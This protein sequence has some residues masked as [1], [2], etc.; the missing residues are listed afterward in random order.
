VTVDVRGLVQVALDTILYPE[1][2]YVYWLRKTETQGQD[3]DE[4]VVYT[5]DGDI[6][7]TSDDGMAWVKAANIAVRYYYRDSL[8]ETRQ[9]R[10]KIKDREKAIADA[11]ISAGFSIANGP[12]DAGDI[13]DIG[14]GT[15]I[16]ECDHRRKDLKS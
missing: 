2:V 9:G 14:F 10:G 6:P 7:S 5:L 1:S 15:T 16:F 8:L 13:D 12:F 3:P 11:L 4:Y